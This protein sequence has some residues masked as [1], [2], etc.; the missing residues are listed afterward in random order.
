MSRNGAVSTASS[1]VKIWTS[2]Y[3]ALLFL[4]AG[5]SVAVVPDDAEF[6]PD[7]ARETLHSALDAWKDGKAKMLIRLS[8]PIRFVDDD[9]SA[10]YRLV[11]Y[12]FDPSDQA[13]RPFQNIS[14]ALTLRQGNGPEVT[15]TAM[16]QVSLEP[17]LAVLRSD[18]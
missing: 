6:D 1:L 3:S 15:R 8:P 7:L 13:I 12:E 2:F 14:V 10:G 4:A 17:A 9:L 5:C 11:D 18:P 16:Y